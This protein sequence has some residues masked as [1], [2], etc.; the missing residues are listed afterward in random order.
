M[1]KS[2]PAKK[3][4]KLPKKSEEPEEDV[5]R[6]KLKLIAPKRS[7]KGKLTANKGGLYLKADNDYEGWDPARI[8]MGPPEERTSKTGD[9]PYQEGTILYRYK[10]PEGE[11]EAPLR[12][13]LP[14][15]PKTTP[16]A[17]SGI[18]ERTLKKEGSKGPGKPLGKYHMVTVININ[19]PGA[20]KYIQMMLDL[21]IRCCQWLEEHG[22]G[23]KGSKKLK[24]AYSAK[25]IDF[26]NPMNNFLPPIM[27]EKITKKDEDGGVSQVCNL[28]KNYMIR[29]AIQLG[30]SKFSSK[31]FDKHNNPIEQNE[32]MDVNV[33]FVP[34]QVFSTIYHGAQ[35]S[36]RNGV[37]SALVLDYSLSQ[38]HF[39]G[40]ALEM[41]GEYGSTIDVLRA[42]SK[43]TLDEDDEDKKAKPSDKEE[44]TKSSSSSSTKEES[45][46]E[47]KEE[48][49][50]EE[51]EDEK[52]RRRKKRPTARD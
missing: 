31:F 23:K 3:A 28:S 8:I 38:E 39:Q 7:G 33:D 13:Q 52:P 21:Y 37:E 43:T 2:R 15:G 35:M 1:S 49:E 12:I 47:E 4:T 6:P 48:K 27:F 10:T 34:M 20:K 50:K 26:D 9:V 16:T 25:D 5:E 51:E 44:S 45:E 40:D 41:F 36:I 19:A 17:P 22:S 42:K 11:I 18:R 14:A 30:K 32:L 46:E 29:P 24:N